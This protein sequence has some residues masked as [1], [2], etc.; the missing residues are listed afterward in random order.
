MPFGWALRAAGHEVM[1]A[2]HPS[3]APTITAAGLPALPAG[4]HVDLV[5]VLRD[6]LAKAGWYD[7]HRQEQRKAKADKNWSDAQRLG[8]GAGMRRGLNVLRVAADSAAAMADDTVRFIDRWR[9]DA[10]V[11]EPF[12]FLGPL[13]AA[14][15]DVPALRLLWT[16]DFLHSVGD[17]EEELLGELAAR[18]GAPRINA[19]GD[20]TL[21]P[22]PPR[23]QVVDDLERQPMRYVPYNGPAVEPAWLRRPKRRRRICVTWG[24]SIDGL[25]LNDGLLAPAVVRELGKH[26]VE[27]VVAVVE[28]QRELF[29]EL[30]ENVVNLGRVPLDQ[31]LADCDA[32]IHQGGGGTTMTAVKNGVPQ[33]VLPILPDTMFNAQHVAASKAGTYLWGG[34]AWGE[35]L[36]HELGQYLADLDRYQEE[37]AQMRAEHLAM[38]SPAD[39]VSLL[40]KRVR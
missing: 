10:V 39:V 14:R 35:R 20:L 26:D 16:V 12:G 38:P 37:A 9:P 30:P 22:C 1:V 31:A 28:S 18:I 11:Y 27:T 23:L 8:S 7:K 21:D 29:G 40:E 33:F 6:T 2:S 4:R 5:E 13:I 24:T 36:T 32:I 3:F 19:V 17:V 25:A 34:D 15:L